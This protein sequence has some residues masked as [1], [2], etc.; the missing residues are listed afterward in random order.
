[1]PLNEE[2]R[3]GAA[4]AGRGVK[5]R[6]GYSFDSNEPG[7]RRRIASVDFDLVEPFGVEAFI[8]AAFLFS[9]FFS[10]AAI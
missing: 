4:L 7:S 8:L 3:L 1:L 10:R 2:G 9:A 6:T 5:T